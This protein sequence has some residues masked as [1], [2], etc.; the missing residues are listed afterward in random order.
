MASG[1]RTDTQ[2]QARPDDFAT[3]T[4]TKDLPKDRKTS[5]LEGSSVVQLTAAQ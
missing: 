5:G 1:V 4:P 2:F 3:G